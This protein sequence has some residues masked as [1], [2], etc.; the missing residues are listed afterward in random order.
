MGTQTERR[1]RIKKSPQR[2]PRE[3]EKNGKLTKALGIAYCR[4]CAAF[5]IHYRSPLPNPPTSTTLTLS[6]I[7]LGLSLTWGLSLHARRDATEG[8]AARQNPAGIF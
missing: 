8:K 5:A 3:N 2:R 4:A 7:W 6:P 1:R